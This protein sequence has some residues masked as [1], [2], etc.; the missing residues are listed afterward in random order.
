MNRRLTVVSPVILSLIIAAC[1]DG[2]APAVSA[3]VA[4]AE[5]LLK[6]VTNPAQLEQSIK[7]GFTEIRDQRVF[8]EVQMLA[9]AASADGNFTGTYTQEARVDELDAVRYDGSYLYIAPRRYFNCCFRAAVAPGNG[10]DNVNTPESSIRILETDPATGSA[11]LVSTIPLDDDISVQGMY[12]EDDRMFALTGTS[13]YGHF[14]GMWADV[15][16]WS[17][18]MLGYRVY[19]LSDRAAP[20]LQVDATI[21]GVFVDSR[22]IGN[23]VYIV[24]RYSPW[25]EDI[26]YWVTTVAQQASNEAVLADVPLDDLLPKITVNG[27]TRPLIRPEDCYIDGSGDDDGYPVL[28]SITAVPLDDPETF[29]T[30]CYNQEAYGAYVSENAIYFTEFHESEEGDHYN[31]RIHKFALFDTS[32]D[33]RGSADIDGQVWRGGQSDFRMSEHNGDLRVLATKFDWGNDDWADHKLTVLRESAIDL[34]LDVV[35][36]LPNE[37]RPQEIG[38]PNEQ[39]YGVRFFG[40]RVYAVTF[41]RIDPLYVI[42]LG[43][44]ADPYIAGELEVT[45]FSDFLHPVNDKLLLG[46]GTG[47]GGGIKLELFDVSDISQPLSRGSTVLGGRGS[48]SE[49]EYDRHAFTYQ[50]TSDKLDRFTI[51]ADV[52]SED[53]N[54]EYVESGLYLFEI[55]DKDDPAFATLA[56]AGSIVPPTENGFA[57]WGAG[58][59][60]AFI[61]DDTVYYVRDETVWSATWN[62]PMIVN[63]PF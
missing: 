48:Y 36:E 32:V 7:S 54:Y 28:T 24:S 21:E 14:G 44:P 59:S 19:D 50:V 37:D 46:L 1:S 2:S 40:D 11:S 27:V 17:P 9:A 31:T 63:G 56:P 23:T 43:D 13:V 6:Q 33:Y 18:E 10:N 57:S 25:I 61:H 5:G 4:P 20:Q 3:P 16:S 47:G 12:V 60:R 55:R 45:G 41:E 51:P 52:Y 42:D 35:S 38:K 29:T 30:T 39:L 62:A 15:A 58:R 49:A 34:E 22:R 53:N 8:A 26:D